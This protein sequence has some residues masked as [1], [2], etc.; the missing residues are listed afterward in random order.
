MNDR[1]EMATVNPGNRPDALERG[2]GFRFFR[3]PWCIKLVGHKRTIPPGIY[4]TAEP[5]VAKTLARCV[6]VEELAPDHPDVAGAIAVKATEQA[7]AGR[8]AQKLDRQMP[9]WRETARAHAARAA[10]DRKRSQEATAKQRELSRLAEEEAARE[11]EQEEARRQAPQEPTGTGAP[12]L[13]AQPA[14]LV[15]SDAAGAVLEAAGAV[16]SPVGS[17][18]AEAARETMTLA[19]ADTGS[20]DDVLGKPSE[21]DPQVGATG[22]AEKP[23]EQ[24]DFMTRAAIKE[25]LTRRGVEFHA[26]ASIADLRKIARADAG[27]G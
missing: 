11:R 17:K 12:S 25:H 23:G 5:D 1:D 9:D 16:F 21:P 2:S 15:P 6:G 20:V 3:V 27:I 19:P 4:P 14:G 13:G 10:A 24:F 18:P 7:G 22:Q 26:H 8:V